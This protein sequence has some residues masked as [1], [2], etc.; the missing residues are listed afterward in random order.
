MSHELRT[1]LNGVLGYAQLLQRDR[2]LTPTQREALEAIAKCGSQLLDLINDVLDLSKIEAGRFDIEEASTDLA[3][4]TT[5][6]RSVVGEA[7]EPQGPDADDD[8]SARTCRAVGGPRR[9]AAAAGAAESARQRDQV[10]RGRRR[11]AGDQR[12]RRALVFEVTDT[13]PGIEPD[14]IDE[15]LRG[16][17]ADEERRGRGRHRPRAGHLRSTDLDDGRRAEGRRACSA[18][19]AASGSRCR[20]SRDGAAAAR[21]WTSSN[22]S[23]RHSTRGWHRVRRCSRWSWTTTSPTATSCRACSRAPASACVTAA[24]G[25]DAIE[26]ARADRPQIIF[27][28]LKMNDLDGFE[29]TRRLAS[30]PATSSIPV[31][32][33]T[34][35]ALGNSRQRARDAGCVDYLSK[36]VRAELLYG[37]LQ[38]HVGARFVSDRDIAAARQ[39]RPGRHRSALRDRRAAARRDR[40]RRRRRDPA[41]RHVRSC[42]A[43]APNPPSA[44]ASTA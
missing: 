44:S 33:V 35:S 21:N 23:C 43:A 41:A 2:G 16:V 4:L 18:K 27:M 29:A 34:A 6:L 40:A 7:A 14:A 10:H 20:S 1:P 19:A 3:K 8:A 28:D 15:D 42:R 22:P 26:R 12:R 32:A 11:A 9:T 17:R 25:L 31:V 30:D 24:G 37:M 5:D 36:P 39:R 38:A 13:G